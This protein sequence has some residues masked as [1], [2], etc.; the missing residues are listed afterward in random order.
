MS[1]KITETDF[2]LEFN[3]QL[4]SH[5][6]VGHKEIT[7]GLAKKNTNYFDI[8]KEPVQLH[9]RQNGSHTE[10]SNFLEITD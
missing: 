4:F 5:H 1:I 2:D 6:N 3:S 7:K 9:W 8:S 10:I